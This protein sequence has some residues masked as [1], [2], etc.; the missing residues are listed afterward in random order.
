MEANKPKVECKICHK[1]YVD[2][3]HHHRTVHEILD[4]NCH[5]CSGSNSVYS[6][7]SLEK[8]IKRVHKPKNVTKKRKRTESDEKTCKEGY[9]RCRYCLDQIMN[10]NLDSHMKDKDCKISSLESHLKKFPYP[11]KRKRDWLISQIDQELPDYNARLV[12]NKFY[13]LIMILGLNFGSKHL[14]FKIA[15]QLGAEHKLCCL[16]IGN[17]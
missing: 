3:A 9:S 14:L 11:N 7:E 6:K 2:I 5:L 10:K 16:K 1:S 12:D 15:T 8:H 17:V 4:Q 13:Y